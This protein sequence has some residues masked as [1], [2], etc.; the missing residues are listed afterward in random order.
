MVLVIKSE[1]ST[2]KELSRNYATDNWF[3]VYQERARFEGRRLKWISEKSYEIIFSEKG[4]KLSF[5]MK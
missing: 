4:Y 5:E 2:G 3:N 1:I